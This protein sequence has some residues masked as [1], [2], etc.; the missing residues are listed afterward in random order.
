MRDRQEERR[1]ARR[2]RRQAPAEQGCA[3]ERAVERMT[4]RQ[5]AAEA[6]DQRRRQYLKGLSASRKRSIGK[7]GK[8]AEAFQRVVYSALGLSHTAGYDGRPPAFEP[9]TEV[10]E[11][12]A[13]TGGGFKNVVRDPLR[14]LHRRGEIDEIQYR[15]ANAFIRLWEAKESGIRGI[16]YGERVDGGKMPDVSETALLTTRAVA[17]FRED[18]GP[19]QVYLLE[20]V[21]IQ[22]LPIYRVAE[23][24]AYGR[25]PRTVLKALRAAL[26]DAA[27]SLLPAARG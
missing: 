15:A 5:A 23:L 14:R 21:C 4:I 18:L 13:V 24:G 2:E 17:N 26:N 27:S 9:D 20:L 7:S 12:S 3:V 6:A 8:A 16:N 25:D 1:R 10:N 22:G 11:S 19:G